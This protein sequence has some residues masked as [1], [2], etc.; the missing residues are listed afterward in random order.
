MSD[1]LSEDKISVSKS[2]DSIRKM[3]I[4]L[5]FY[6]FW[7]NVKLKTN[8]MEFSDDALPK[9][10]LDEANTCLSQCG[11]EELDAVNPYDWIFLCSAR[12]QSPLEYF[13]AMI[14][15]LSDDN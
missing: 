11:Y 14:N 5:N 15:E 9:I 4:L 6:H 13:R 2:Y 10:Y 3:I 8:D 12:S 7:V 1:I